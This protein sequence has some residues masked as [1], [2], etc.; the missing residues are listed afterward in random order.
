[1]NKKFNIVN[2]KKLLLKKKVS[3]IIKKTRQVERLVLYR[4]SFYALFSMKHYK[5]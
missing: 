3:D 1:M 5:I 2:K 4:A